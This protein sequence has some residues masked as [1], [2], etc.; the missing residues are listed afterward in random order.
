M[1]TKNILWLLFS[2]FLCVGCEDL[3]DTYSDYAGDGEIRYVGKCTDV[4]VSS[5]WKRLIV[6]WKNNPDS[7]I[8]KIKVR[9]GLDAKY[10]SLLFD[11]GTMEC[12]I[13]NLEDGNYEVCVYGVDKDG[14]QSLT[15]PLFGRPYTA[16]HET[17]LSFTRLISKHYFLR[18]RLILFFSTWSDQV[19]SA[20]LNYYEKGGG[21]R[22]LNLNAELIEKK[23]YMLPEGIDTSKPVILERKGRVEGCDD[24]IIFD[25]YELSK[26]KVFNPEFKQLM[27]AK[28]GLAEISEDFANNLEEI[29]INYS[30][31]SFEDILNLPNLK[32][33]ILGKNRFMNENYLD[34]TGNNSQLYDQEVSL[35]ALNVANE[36]CGLIVERYNRHFL[37]EQTLAYM[38]EMGNPVLP[39]LIP[40]DSKDWKITCEPEDEDNYD[41]Y[42]NN[43]VD[44][45]LKTSWQPEF[46][47]IS[48]SHEISI[49]M[50]A[51]RTVRGVKITQ[52][53]FDPET[54]KASQN[55][56]PSVIK[57][58]VL[59]EDLDEKEIS[60]VEENTL[61][62]TAGEATIINFHA[63]QNVRYLKFIVSDQPYGNNFTLA[64]AEIEVF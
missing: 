62:A 38:T 7:N 5:G 46:A 51:T 35:F 57:I 41:S 23:Y 20:V 32:K 15:T 58:K 4:E 27:R 10:D 48:R 59:T 53:D 44:K 49:D 64:L 39:E 19:E 29:E 56:L 2:F 31:N 12:I 24:L 40:L 22:T 3:E 47:S 52:K 11:A 45:N 14:N 61:G 36:V 18:D 37:P 43:L 25:P 55:L 63:A 26:E 8:D 16:T 42:L 50:K 13:P 6:S 1:K 30:I 60:Y 9:W 34:L 21:F 33:L 28:Y 54:D 17:I